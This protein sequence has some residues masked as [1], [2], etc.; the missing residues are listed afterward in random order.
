MDE[1]LRK[2]IA[3]KRLVSFVLDG[4]PRIGEPHDYGII[5]SIP[6]LFFYQTG[7]RSRSKPPVGWRWAALSKIS[8]LRILDERFAGPRPAPS[9]RHIRWDKLIATVS[10]RAGS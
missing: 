4:Y 9:G 2:A 7:G 3:E 1:L 6:K 10:P 5:N 8:G